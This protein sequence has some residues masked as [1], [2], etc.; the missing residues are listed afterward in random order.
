[1]HLNIRYVQIQNKSGK[2]CLSRK[3]KMIYKLELS[4][5]NE[6]SSPRIL[7]SDLVYLITNQ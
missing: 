1:M 7:Q 6:Y 5:T 4:S 3:D 2:M